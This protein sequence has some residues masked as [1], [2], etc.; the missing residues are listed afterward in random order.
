MLKGLKNN[1]NLKLDLR[2]NVIIDATALLELNQNTK[3]D[4][5]GNANLSQ[6]SKDKLK[7]RFRNN[8]TL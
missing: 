1:T 3:I 5:R 4:L 2:N 8:V 7:A 6:E